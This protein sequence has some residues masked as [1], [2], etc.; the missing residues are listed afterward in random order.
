[1]FLSFQLELWFSLF[2]TLWNQKQKSSQPTVLFIIQF[3]KKKKAW[4]DQDKDT[5][6]KKLLNCCVQ[7]FWEFFPDYCDDIRMIKTMTITSF[8]CLKIFSVQHHC[9]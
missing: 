3:K 7:P 5:A 9:F 4:Q 1:M 2:D 8:F 6:L